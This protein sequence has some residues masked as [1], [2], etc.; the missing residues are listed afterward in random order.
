MFVVI[1]NHVAVGLAWLRSALG[2]KC[3]GLAEV[4]GL[5]LEWN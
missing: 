1:Y 2:V 3:K 5:S 4:G